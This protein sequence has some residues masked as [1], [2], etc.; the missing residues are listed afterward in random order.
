MWYAMNC[1]MEQVEDRVNSDPSQILDSELAIINRSDNIIHNTHVCK[2][3][4]YRACRMM[5]TYGHVLSN[6]E[7]VKMIL[8]DKFD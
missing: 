2:S 7:L 6:A 5:K 4:Y 1:K 3:R 8:L